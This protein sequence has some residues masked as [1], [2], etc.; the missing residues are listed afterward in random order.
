MEPTGY[1]SPTA[2][3]DGERV[4]VFFATADL[5][6][7]DFQ[8]NLVWKKHLGDPN[9][10]YGIATSPIVYDGKVILQFDRGTMPDEDLS[11]LIA[12]DPKTGEE[13]WSVK[14]PVVNSW[15]TPVV[16]ETETGIELI[17]AAAPWVISYDPDMGT[18]LW[19]A[20]VLSGDVAPSPVVARN[21]S[22]VTNEYAKVAAVQTGGVGDVTDTKVLWTA[23]DGMSDAPS[24]ICDGRLFLQVHSRGRVTCYDAAEGKMV[25]DE[26]IDS[27]F[28]A[29]PTL[30]GDTVYLPS[31]DGKVYLFELA[32]SFDLSVTLDMG[33]PVL[34]TPAFADS[35]IYIRGEQH[36]FCIGTE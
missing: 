25:W 3:T 1:A 16:T 20:Q 33:E 32:E 17:T 28:W 18:E 4:Y 26:T 22:Y 31:A 12:F 35:R 14:R 24:P 9:N 11:R 5:A 10:T 23:Q 34:A 8:G 19:R 7:V 13:V 27:P 15:S 30:V 21:V 6:A 29:S 36:L 2:A